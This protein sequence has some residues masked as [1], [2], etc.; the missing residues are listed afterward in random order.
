[1]SHARTYFACC[2]LVLAACA[3]K[4]GDKKMCAGG[5]PCAECQDGIDNDGDGLIDYPNDPGCFAPQQNSEEDDCPMGPNCPQCGNGID[6]DGNGIIDFSGNDPG[7]MSAADPLE[8]TENPAACGQTMTIKQLPANGVDSGMI[9]G[10][11]TFSQISPCGGGGGSIAAVAYELHVLHPQVLVISSAGSSISVVLDLRSA[12]CA[13]SGSEVT[14]SHSVDTATGSIDITAPVAAGTYF[15]L[16]ESYNGDS[17]GYAISV[18]ELP[19][20]GAACMQDSDCGT[21]LECKNMTCVEQEC[22]NGVDDDGDGKIDYPNDPGCDTPM[23]DDETD[24][25]PSGPNCPQC[26]NGIDDDMDGEIDYP[27]DTS[28]KSASGTSEFC[29]TTEGVTNLTQPLTMGDLTGATDDYMPTCAFESGGLDLTYELELPKTTTI[30]IDVSDPSFTD[31]PDA[32]LLGPTCGGTEL[33]CENDEPITKTNLAAGNYYL[34]VD[35]DDP[36]DPG[37]FQIQI[38]GVIANGQSCES[39][40]AQSGALACANGYACKGT[41]GSRTCAKAECSDGIDNDGDGKIDY[42]NDPGCD[43]PSDDDETD[44]PTPPVCSNGVDDDMD[45]KTDFPADFGCSSA[46]GASEVFCAMETDAVTVL[47]AATTTINPTALTGNFTLPCSDDGF[48]DEPDDG[49]KTYALEIPE[50]LATL[51]IDTTGSANDDTILELWD[52]QCDSPGYYCNDNPADF[53]TFLGTLTLTDVAPGNYA[54]TVGT[55]DKTSGNI[56]LTMS[57]TVAKGSVCTG[58][59]FTSAVLKCAAGSTCTSGKCQ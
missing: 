18:Q 20:V 51:K 58:A 16:V 56:K 1:M 57:G 46:A 12:A 5:E 49:D 10:T 32:V 11:Q 8:F 2:L 26:G 33:D 36:S 22:R 9:D 6:D 43:T 15:L 23:D 50:W 38:S 29:N 25:C 53:S 19:G 54:L 35:S 41:V 17:G 3:A 40:L 59:L 24:D 21:S 42:P 30:T 48:G 28:C 31:F 55:F 7:C 44:P 13:Q 37:P 47:T 4:N 52:T 14:C 27:A 39:P 45:G 34:V